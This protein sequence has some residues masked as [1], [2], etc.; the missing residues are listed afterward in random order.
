MFKQINSLICSR[1][2]SMSMSLVI[3]ILM[4]ALMEKDTSGSMG[5]IWADIGMLGL[6]KDYFVLG[7]GSKK[8][9]IKSIFLIYGDHLE[10]LYMV[11]KHLE[12]LNPKWT[13]RTVP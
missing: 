9:K 3:P 7:S 10:L 8:D 13:K 11:S 6:K 1:E 4:S 2:A 5:E 12:T